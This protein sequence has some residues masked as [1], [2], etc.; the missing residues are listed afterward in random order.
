ME[1]KYFFVSHQLAIPLRGIIIIIYYYHY[2]LYSTMPQ[3]LATK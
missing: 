1:I 3:K 2:L